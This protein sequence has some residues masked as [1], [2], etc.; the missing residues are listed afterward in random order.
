MVTDNKNIQNTPFIVFLKHLKLR[1]QI[2]I[3]RVEDQNTQ[4][5]QSPKYY[6]R[7]FIRNKSWFCYSFI[8]RSSPK[9]VSIQ[10]VKCIGPF[11]RTDSFYCMQ[12]LHMV[13][14]TGK[15]H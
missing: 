13:I 10:T 4:I 12:S 3:E 15:Y 14:L 1:K 7:T 8:A 9:Y 2:N 5:E 6:N 11:T